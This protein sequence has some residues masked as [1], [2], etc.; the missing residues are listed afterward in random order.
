[1]AYMMSE[2]RIVPVIGEENI[3]KKFFMGAFV[4]L[5]VSLNQIGMQLKFPKTT[6]RATPDM[7]N[8]MVNG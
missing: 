6:D 4:I 8:N 2:K 3:F 7:L 1:M 5:I